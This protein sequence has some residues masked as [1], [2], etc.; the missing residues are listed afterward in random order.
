MTPIQKFTETAIPKL[1]KQLEY[2]LSNPQ[3]ALVTTVWNQKGGVA[4]TTN[5]I[6]LGQH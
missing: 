5:T 6:N 3:S 4:K 2:C 1:L